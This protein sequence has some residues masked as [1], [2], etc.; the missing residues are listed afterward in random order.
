MTHEEVGVL[1]ETLKIRS[2]HFD[3]SRLIGTKK[4]WEP[5]IVCAEQSSEGER[6]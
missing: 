2:P 1:L 3:F 5:Q 4:E 6:R